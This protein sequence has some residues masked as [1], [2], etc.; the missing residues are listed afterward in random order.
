MGATDV[1]DLVF[2]LPA[3]LVGRP[4]EAALTPGRAVPAMLA[5]VRVRRAGAGVAQAVPTVAGLPKIL[6]AVGAPDETATGSQPVDIEREMGALLAAVDAAVM[7]GRAQVRIL[8]VTSP[9]AIAAAV[10]DGYHV[11]LL[12]QKRQQLLARLHL[13]G[14]DATN[15]DTFQQHF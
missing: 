5:G 10:I 2:E 13:S 3:A 4:V 6:A 14:T 11:V 7:N 12:G 1:A 15:R 8:A 9:E